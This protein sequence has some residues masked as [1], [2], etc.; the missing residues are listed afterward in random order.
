M[1][2][3]TLARHG[4]TRIAAA[5][6][7]R[8]PCD[9]QGT[10]PG[11]GPD[12]RRTWHERGVGSP[13]SPPRPPAACA[14]GGAQGRSEGR[15]RGA[16]VDAAEEVVQVR[17]GVPLRAL[18]A[19]QRLRRR[20]P[21]VRARAR[22]RQAARAGRHHVRLRLTRAACV[23]SG[24]S[25]LLRSRGAGDITM[26]GC[27]GARS[28]S[29]VQARPVRQKPCGGRHACYIRRL[30]AAPGAASGLG[31]CSARHST[32]GAS[33]SRSLW[34]AAYVWCQ[35]RRQRPGVQGGVKLRSD[36]RH[37]AWNQ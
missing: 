5:A 19:E 3:S 13:D 8:P 22:L 36:G 29:Y 4:G 15:A 31:R 33:S 18:A 35:Q 17:N 27:A 26:T 34:Q 6:A 10:G 12:A 28:R 16:L 11:Q 7:R 14:T 30:A 20:V 23:H 25:R 9:R 1:Q 37:A 24:R 32:E 21:L 2:P